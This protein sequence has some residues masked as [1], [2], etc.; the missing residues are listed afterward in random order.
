MDQLKEGDQGSIVWVP[1][2]AVDVNRKSFYLKQVTGTLY[3]W[4]LTLKIT[5]S[6]LNDVDEHL[7]DLAMCDFSYDALC[8]HWLLLKGVTLL[9]SV[10]HFI[11]F[12]MS[13]HYK[14]PTELKMFMHSFRGRSS[15]LLVIVNTASLKFLLLEFIICVELNGR[16]MASA[17]IC[18]ADNQ[19]FNF[20]KYIFDNMVKRLEG[21]VK[22]YLFPRFLQFFLDKQVEGMR[23]EAEVSNDESED[24]D[25]VPSPSSDP[26]PSGEDRF[27]LNELMV[28]CTSLQEH[29]LD[30]QE[31]K[32]AQA[33]EIAT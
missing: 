30:L 17:I 2:E 23:N 12:F 27:I 6:C 8:I 31:A 32:V 28:F 5:Y 19:K 24:K 10:S 4:T 33:K 21:G 25:H 29:V 9:C 11:V 20:P 16:T 18:L 7:K 15:Q 1:S 13:N 26:L 22:F 3:Y 14:K